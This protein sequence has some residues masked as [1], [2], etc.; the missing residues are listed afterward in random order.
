MGK[1]WID[2][3]DFKDF[4][5]FT[6]E[7]Q[8]VRE[9][10]QSYLLANGTGETLKPAT[11]TFTIKESG[12]HRFYI[13]T[14]NWVAEH[15]PDGL[16]IEV[17]GVK[18]KHIC[19]KMHIRDWYFEIGAD[20]NLSVGEHT[21]K[22][23]DTTGW[24]AR[25]ACVI[26]TNDY[27]YTPPKEITLLKK[28]RLEIKGIK[29]NLTDH[30]NYDL[31]V[32]GGGAAGV[33]TAIS[34]ARYGLKVALLNDRPILGGNGSEEG[35]VAFEGSAHRGYQDTGIIYEIKNYR[36][37]HKVT[38]TKALDDIISKEINIDVFKN[39][40]LLESDTENNFITKIKAVNTYDLTEHTF[41]A[42][43]FADCS[44]DAWLGYYSGA[45]YRIGRE[46]K[47]QHDESFAPEN[48][49]GNTMSGCATRPVRKFGIDTVC[50]Y[51]A[52]ET[53]KEIKFK[54]PD[55]AFKLPDGDN[56]G[57]VP[58]NINR[59]SWWHEL[60]NDYDDLFENEFVRDSMIRMAVGYFDWLKNSWTDCEKAKNYKL[61]GLGTHNSKRETRRLIGDYIMTENDFVEGRDYPDSVCYCGWNIDV[62]HVDG[63]FSGKD[64]L[65]TL[66]KKIPITPVPFSSLYSKNINNLMMAGRCISVT[67][68]GLG[69]T[70]VI[71]T[72]AMMGQ[73]IGTAAY[74]GKKYNKT[75][76][77]IKNEHIGELQQLLLKDGIW[78]P[79]VFNSDPCDLART[80]TVTANSHAEN[81]NPENIINGKTRK[82]DG[83]DYAW[84]SQDAAPQSITLTFDDEKEISQARLTFEMPFD[85]YPYGYMEMPE[86]SD[87]VTDFKVSVLTNDGWKETA[88]IKGNFQRLVVCDFEKV[89]AK[90]VKVT[91]LKTLNSE[92]VIIPEIRIY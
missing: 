30:G 71:M 54:A 64:G 6:V 88:N 77:E 81:G 48:A 84:I 70:R 75:P 69:P 83:E 85:K 50:S 2:A 58:N 33:C 37:Y 67:H 38:W 20:F 91:V 16:I 42:T 56:L 25:F 62:H 24:F 53:E 13:R 51:F 74:L 29:A 1:L 9:M 46:A 87:V 15:S 27:D 5:G 72:G 3:I 28:H 41:S 23:Y 60:Q 55:W 52:E 92:N 79:Y 86:T 82:T 10:G 78:I 73:A 47:F 90:A 43:Y 22:I 57:R 19:G 35:S 80:A 59:G 12:M 26:I 61:T 17:D 7:S 66:D 49:D 34:A 14:K 89:N 8:F 18:S 68:I 76:R 39:T 11:V 31:I 63:I 36:H 45:A 21:L 44:G 32:V 4:G 65:F 40:L